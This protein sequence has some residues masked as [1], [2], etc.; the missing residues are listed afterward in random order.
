MDFKYHHKTLELLCSKKTAFYTADNRG[1][2]ISSPEILSFEYTAESLSNELE[3]DSYEKALSILTS[4]KQFDCLNSKY[5]KKINEVIFWITDNGIS[6]YHEQYFI[7]KLK[8]QKQERTLL[9]FKYLF[10]FISTIGIISS[11][12]YN[13][14][15]TD[16]L[17]NKIE[18]HK[19]IY[20]PTHI[21]ND[22]LCKCRDDSLIL[23]QKKDTNDIKKQP[24]TKL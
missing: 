9:V 17:L 5:N 3:I 13:K 21:N 19:S 18:N 23:I 10:Y 1:E 7:Y 24:I 12:I 6:K 22:S 4:L 8:T 20:E 2:T 15:S 11:V 14:V 16:I